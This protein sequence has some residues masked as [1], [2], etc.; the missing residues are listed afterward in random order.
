MEAPEPATTLGR[1][2]LS[3]ARRAGLIVYLVVLVPTALALAVVTMLLLL[4]LITDPVE[5]KRS[6]PVILLGLVMTAGGVVYIRRILLHLIR[7]G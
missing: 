4:G 7:G 6:I 2:R 1:P 3:P 5:F